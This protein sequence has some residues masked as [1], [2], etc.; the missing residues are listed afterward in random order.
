M[1]TRVGIN[2]F[3]R[4]GRLALRA[5]WGRQ[6]LQF[7]HVNE[8]AGNAESA[9]HLL[10]FD[11]VHGRWNKDVRHREGELLVANHSVT[12]SSLPKPGQVPWSDYGCRCRARVQR[13]VPHS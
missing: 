1:A 7:V 2:G 4:M 6:D 12:Y 13:Q 3:G 9:A 8:V 5:G 11:S 10:M